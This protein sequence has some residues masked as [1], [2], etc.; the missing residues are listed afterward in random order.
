MAEPHPGSDQEDF[1]AGKKEDQKNDGD[2]RNA[3]KPGIGPLMLCVVHGRMALRNVD[4][5]VFISPDVA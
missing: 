4:T 5:H 1:H 2:F 3:Q